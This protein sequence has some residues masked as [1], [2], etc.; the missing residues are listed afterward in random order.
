MPTL[1]WLDRAEF[2]LNPAEAWRRG[3]L[4]DRLLKNAIPPHPRGAFRASYAEL[5]RLDDLRRVEIA[6]YL[7]SG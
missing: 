1:D 5:N 7:N 2:V 3:R 6:R 4:L